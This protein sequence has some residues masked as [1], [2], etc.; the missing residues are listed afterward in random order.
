[1]RQYLLAKIS[2]A[3]GVDAWALNEPC[4]KAVRNRRSL[5]RELAAQLSESFPGKKL[6]ITSL[7][8]GPAAE[9]FECIDAYN[10]E[11]NM[12]DIDARARLVGVDD[13]INAIQDNIIKM[14]LGRS[15]D[16]PGGQHGIYGLGVID[17]FHDEL[18]V[19]LLNLIH[20]KLVDG[21]IMLLGNFRPDHPNANFFVHALDWPLFLRS[22]QHL[23]GFVKQSKFSS[24]PVI[25]G[26]ESEGVQLFI[27]CV[28]VT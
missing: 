4:P 17:Y 27:R 9:V 13:R 7:G 23:A 22:E 21:G 6:S 24:C 10:A 19:R 18:V 28:K 5:V 25:V 3:R 2:F 14:T 16:F 11:F 20:E 15:G 12:I 8:C 26:T 1:M